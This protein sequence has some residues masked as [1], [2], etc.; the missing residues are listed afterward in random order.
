MR[1]ERYRRQGPRT[2]EDRPRLVALRVLQ[3][4]DEDDAFANLALPVALRKEQQQNPRFTFR[5]SAFASELVYGTLRQQG[6]LD[7]V[8]IQFCSRPLDQLDPIVH[9]ILRM[10]AYQLL[11]MRVPD[12][13]A[14]AETVNLARSQA[15]E[16]A[17]KLTNAVLRSITR[18]SEDDLA[19]IFAKIGDED[20]RLAALTSHPQWVVRSFRN[21]LAAHGGDSSALEQALRANNET[22][23]VNL[24]AR[25][26]LISREE[27]ME[28]VSDVLGR[29]QSTSELSPYAVVIDGGDPGALPAVR[30]GAAA[31]QDHGSQLAALI[32]ATAPLTGPDGRW[33]DLCAGPGG[34]AA[35]LAAV[36]P[37]KTLV[38]AN[39][40][41]PRRAGLV[42]RSVQALDNVE[43]LVGD[44]R[45][46]SPEGG[47]FDRV[48]V[49]AP[50]SGLGSLRRRPESRWRHQPEDLEE[51]IPLQRSL[52]SAGIE[53]TRSGGVVAWVT[54]TPQVEETLDQVELAL[55]RGDVELLDAREVA[56]QIS[57]VFTER[58]QRNGA[59]ETTSDLAEKTVQLWPHEHGA[60]AMFVALLRKL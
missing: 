15:S 17:A 10:G 2:T 13:A 26:G 20:E 37:P 50:C 43:V 60:D 14:V 47:L 30:S 23:L 55:T 49:D 31:V 11:F 34:K 46:F 9:L 27:L 53:A 12:H 32:L 56:G 8:L 40:V 51:L 5:D 38:V 58:S 41:N 1:E 35:L 7:T 44:G 59:P 16:G 45:R 25:P 22:P 29:S 3:Q 28:E 6:Y 48:L 4:V 33:L 39:E 52:L 19:G 24:V 42:E 54:C 57:P 36:A 18:A 21:A